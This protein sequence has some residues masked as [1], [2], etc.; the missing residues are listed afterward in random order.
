[1][2]CCAIM[3]AKKTYSYVINFLFK[4]PPMHTWPAPM[5]HLYRLGL[6]TWGY[7]V[8]IPVGTDICHHGCA[9][10]VLQTVQRH[11][12][13]GAAYG[14]VQYKGPLDS[15]EIRV[16]HSP[17]FGLHSVAICHDCAKSEVKQ[18]SYIRIILP[19]FDDAYL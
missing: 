9:Y 1:M 18:Y 16:R 11:G 8:R 2:P 4:M 14:T 6:V 15:F 5:A 19:Q 7:H 13:Y 17:G 12:V 10:T 3:R